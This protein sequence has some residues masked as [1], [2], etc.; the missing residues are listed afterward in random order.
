MQTLTSEAQSYLDQQTSALGQLEN[1]ASSGNA[2]LEPS[3]NP[4]GEV[5]VLQNQAQNSGLTADLTNIST[6]QSTLNTSVST[7][8]SANNLITQASQL[9]I[10]ATNSGNDST[11]LDALATEVNSLYNQMINLANTQNTGQY[12]YSGSKAGTQPF[13][14]NSNGTVTYQGGTQAATMPVS[15]TQTVDTL[16][17]GCQVF[18]SQQRGTS[19]YTGSTGAAAGTGTDS[20]TGMGTLTIAHTKTDYTQATPSCGVS[21]GTSAADDTIIG[22]H[23]LTIV[24]TSTEPPDGSQGTVSLDGGP[25]V[26]FTNGDTNLEVTSAT[27]QVVYLNTQNITAGFHGTVDITGEGTITAQGGQPVAITPSANQQVTDGNGGVTNVNT[28]GITQTGTAYVNYT[29]TYDAFQVLSTLRDLMQNTQGMSSGDQMQAISQQMSELTRVSN[30][31]L[32]VVGQQSADLQ[33]L[34]SLQTQTQ[35][36]QLNTKSMI[37]NLSS[38]DMSQVLVQLQAMQ[39]QYQLTLEVT[40]QLF[41]Q[42]LLNF[43]K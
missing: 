4:L 39:T 3:D 15:G 38:A 33:N 14:V 17:P 20:A 23:T 13:T 26:S 43:I 42:N 9:A 11:S 12:L 6:A 34:S 8:Q 7:L 5:S 40:A 28:I 41:S 27:G 36:V 16:C 24:D 32:Q 2:I 21:A 18:Q 37:S 22:Q 30:N 10:E 31:I 35:N 29:G 19:V 25:T 1:Q